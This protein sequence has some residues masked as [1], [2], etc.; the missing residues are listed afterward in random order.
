MGR[1]SLFPAATRQFEAGWRD[2]SCMVKI[3]PLS[4]V[5]QTGVAHSGPQVSESPRAVVERQSGMGLGAVSSSLER[6]M[7]IAPKRHLRLQAG[8]KLGLISCSRGLNE[9][10]LKIADYVGQG[11][12]H[13][14]LSLEHSNAVALAGGEN[15][16]EPKKRADELTRL[17]EDPSIK[18]VVDLSGGKEARHML[19]HLDFARLS[20]SAKPFFG[21]S[22]PSLIANALIS[23]S[24][25][26]AYHLQLMGFAHGEHG[27][28]H[29]ARFQAQ[30]VDGGPNFNT[31]PV[32]WHRGESAQGTVV[33]GNLSALME[34]TRA[35]LA[36]SFDG[37]I[38]LLEAA[39]GDRARTEKRAKELLE[40]GVLEACAGIIVGTFT[41]LDAA[42]GHQAASDIF[43]RYTREFA[44]PLLSTRH[45]GHGWDAHCVPQGYEMSFRRTA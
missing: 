28:G 24:S 4:H 5:Q 45:I 25:G 14:G 2:T 39:S 37:K 6:T 30:F 8:D 44:T 43:E 32:S 21:M 22:D 15:S 35:E 13:L 10:G 23:R 20:Q 18:A 19:E 16:V 31:F 36:P 41:E 1:V 38:L 9:Q 26:T 27:P 29:L 34:L 3:T 12:A 42:E 11:L 17:F 40:R 7:G 33:G